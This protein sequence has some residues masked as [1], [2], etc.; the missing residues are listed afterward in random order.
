MKKIYTIWIY[1]LL[2]VGI[3]F[4]FTNSCKKVNAG[5]DLKTEATV[6]DIDGNTY[7]IIA[8]G[9]QVWMV[10]NLKTTK[11]ND[12]SDVPLVKDSATWAN[13]TTPGYCWYQNDPTYINTT[14]ALYNWYAVNSGKLCP[15]GWH[16]P[17]D[18]EFIAL[19]N[20]LGGG[21]VAGGK[22]KEIGTTNWRSPNMGADNFSGFTALPGGYRNNH[23]FYGI[24]VNG[25]WWT[26]TPVGASNAMYL[27]LDYES[28]VAQR[29]NYI[30]FHG[31]SVR[32]IKD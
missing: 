6:N 10:E 9:K 3:L 31:F 5:S 30:K 22:L 21:S 23:G 25:S 13:L 20:N 19:A 11:Y 18:S 32:C 29:L 15:T 2:I 17:S 8:I 16:V 7:H 14:G 26:T 27:Y 4:M 28:V 1:P 24:D 12:G